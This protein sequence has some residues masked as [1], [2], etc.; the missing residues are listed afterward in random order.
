MFVL[1]QSLSFAYLE[2]NPPNKEFPKCMSFVP[3]PQQANV[4]SANNNKTNNEVALK[5][6]SAAANQAASAAEPDLISD[7]E[8]IFKMRTF[9]VYWVDKY[10]LMYKAGIDKVRE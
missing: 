1:T 5:S 9:D 4:A 3:A 10:A 6:S 2:A 7:E 8:L